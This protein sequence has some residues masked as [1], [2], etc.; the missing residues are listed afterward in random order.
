[1]NPPPACH[2]RQRERIGRRG[3]DHGAG[4]WYTINDVVKAVY[5]DPVL[6]Q[7]VRYFST[8]SWQGDEAHVVFIDFTHPNRVFAYPFEWKPAY[9]RF[10]VFL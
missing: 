4:F 8:G 10:A 5:D 3:H 6:K 7:K 1:M 9:G 2:E